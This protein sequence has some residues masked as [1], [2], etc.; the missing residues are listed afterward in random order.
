M[1]LIVEDGTA[2]DDADSY[3]SVS[4]ADLYHSGRGATQWANLST[5]LKE[6]ALR[7]ATEYMVG[8]YRDQWL[9]RR[10]KSTQALDWPRAGVYLPDLA[11]QA[12]IPT[13]FVPKDV[14]NACAS[15]ALRASAGEL[16]E[17]M[18]QKIIEETIGPITTK[19]DPKSLT[20]KKYPQIDSML[21]MYMSSG[22]NPHMATLVRC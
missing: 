15:L 19:W 16:V 6:Q 1:A 21:K 3:V 7:R 10:A 13:T 4:D 22:G 11:D 2:R 8:E 9:G 18:E 20:K 17:D 5:E 12:S 14:R